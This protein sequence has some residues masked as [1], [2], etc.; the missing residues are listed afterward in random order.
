MKY[1]E[2]GGRCELGRKWKRGREWRREK[3]G[4]VIGKEVELR[5]NV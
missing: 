3:E 5:G 2:E 4:E 1:R